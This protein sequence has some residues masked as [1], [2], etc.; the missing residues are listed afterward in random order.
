MSC[1]PFFIAR[2]IFQFGEFYS[3]DDSSVWVDLLINLIGALVGAAAGA[4]FGYK[5]AQKIFKQETSRELDNQRLER[6]QFYND[7]IAYLALLLDSVLQSWKKQVINFGI[8]AE[9]IRQARAEHHELAITATLNYE[10]L[11]NFDS[12]AFFNAYMH[13]FAQVPER[14]DNFKKMNNLLDFIHLNIA[15]AKEAFESIKNSGYKLRLDFKDMVDELAN[16]CAA[17]LRQK[18]S[19]LEFVQVINQQL[20]VYHELVKKPSSLRS[21]QEQFVIPLNVEMIKNFR[22]IPVSLSIATQC[23]N[24][25][26]KLTDIEG[27]AEQFANFL[28]GLSKKLDQEIGDLANQTIEL[29]KRAPGFRQE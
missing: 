7:R 25:G 23:R 26:V 1:P 9:E 15:K 21:I 28:E 17:T 2:I 4:F 8:L 16:S 24:A 20:S 22:S 10:R 14:V 3:P 18:D 19:N 29:R 11:L 13:V 12:E 27:N 5:Y 6:E